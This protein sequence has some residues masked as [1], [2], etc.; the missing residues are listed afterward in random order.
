MNKIL[1]ITGC[2]LLFSS[3]ALAEET[4]PETCANGAGTVI[5][6]AVSG[7]KYCRSNHF[8]NW[9][10]AYA[11]CDSMNSRL[12]DLSD[13]ACNTTT[14]DCK[15]KCLEITNVDTTTW[16]WTKAPFGPDN[17]YVVNLKT[18]QVRDNYYKRNAGWDFNSY[19]LCY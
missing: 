10:N 19:A 15:N 1:M 8:L 18:G 11:W 13:C 7:H 4:T 14:T 12:F 3:V 5:T 16:S 9:W 6:G 17:A 2:V